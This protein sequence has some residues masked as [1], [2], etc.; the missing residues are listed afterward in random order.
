MKRSL[1]LAASAMIVDAISIASV[2]LPASASPP[3]AQTAPRKKMHEASNSSKATRKLGS[4]GSSGEVGSVVKDGAD[5]RVGAQ[6]NPK[7]V[8][9]DKLRPR[10]IEDVSQSLGPDN[11]RKP[12]QP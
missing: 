7:E 10:E 5:A 4:S 1:L 12:T 11:A 2:A 3:S 8:S 9:I 6:Y